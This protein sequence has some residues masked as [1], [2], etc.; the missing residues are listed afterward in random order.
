MSVSKVT[1]L[2]LNMGGHKVKTGDAK[3]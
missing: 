3:K 2:S 1:G